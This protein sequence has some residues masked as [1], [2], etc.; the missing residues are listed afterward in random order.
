[1]K[2]YELEQKKQKIFDNLVYHNKVGIYCRVSTQDQAREGF[3]LEEQEERLRA[4]C[5]YKGYEIVDVYIDAGISAKDTNRPEFQRMMNDVKAK[6]INRILSL[7]LDRCTRSIMDLEHLVTFLEENDCSLECA[8]EEINTSNANGRFFVRMLTILAQLEIERTSERTMIGLAGALKAKHYPG[9]TPIGYKK[10]NKILEIDD[11]EAPIIKRIFDEYINGMSAC[12]IAKVF[13][14]EN[15]LN[16]SWGST[17]IDRILDNKIYKGEFEAFKTIDDKEN[18][19]IYDMAPKIITNEM[20]EEMLKAKEK[21]THNHYVKHL[22]LFKKKVYCPKCNTQ[23]S[24]VCGTSKNKEKYLYYKCS[25]CKKNIVNENILEQ[26]FMFKMNDLLDYLS[27]VDNQFI[28]VSNKDY[29]NKINDINNKLNILNKQEENSKIMLLNKEISV[30]DL[31]TTL[32][33]I[34]Q[35]KLELK[36]NLSDY[37][38]RCSKLITINN[39][40]FYNSNINTDNKLISYYVGNNNLWYQLDKESK[41]KIINK[42]IDYI[43][44]S[45]LDNNEISIN[46][47]KLKESNIMNISNFRIDIF[48]EIY[49]LDDTS[50]IK[51]IVDNIDID[52]INSNF[53]NYYNLDIKVYNTKSIE[54]TNPLNYIVCT[55]KEAIL[56]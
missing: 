47:I 12:K 45:I 50:F 8:Y 22:Y 26:K 16:R 49:S 46:K 27:I 18:K 25:K 23:L 54:V 21:N 17:T 38:E 3:S 10:V 55:K 36:N 19:I 52:T 5:K 41:F 29:D 48:K 24:C 42:Y 13:T 14:K 34:E 51:D 30:N 15:V 2:G 32:E 35:D 53:L 20:W 43:S 33:K 9:K 37:L 6:K 11:E 40:N 1:M 28:I 31:K 56:N 44:F 39:D 7:K 4:L